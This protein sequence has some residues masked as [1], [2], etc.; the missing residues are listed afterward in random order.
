MENDRGYQEIQ[1][2]ADW[3]LNVWAPDLPSLIEQAA[4]GMFALQQIQLHTQPRLSR[5]IEVDAYDAE[6]L[7]VKFLNEVLYQNEHEGL[8]FDTY[9]ITI[10]GT[11]LGANL[12]GA[13]IAYQAKEIKAVTYH[14]LEIQPRE[15]GL[16]T[17]IVF[18][19]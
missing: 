3:E 16:E 14:K 1:H 12:S 6:G 4:Q 8:G 2:T 15:R 7:L 13:Q 19:V 5:Q 10:D 9:H 17:E 11:H 18:D